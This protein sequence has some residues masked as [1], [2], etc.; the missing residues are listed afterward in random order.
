MDVTKYLELKIAPLAIFDALEERGDRVRFNVPEGD[1]RSPSGYRAV[2]YREFASEIRDAASF[3][4]T[5]LGAED[6]AAIFAP[7]RVEWASASLAI[8]AAGGVLV[9]VYP[10]N[11]A[12]QARYVLDHGDVKVVF[13]DTAPL[14]E[15]IFQI[16]DSLPGLARIALLGDELDWR[17]VRAAA[18]AKGL[19][20]RTH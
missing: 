5:L 14:L 1:P 18:E 4:G 11:T 9:P 17:A 2:T 12:E 16:A 8:Q 10:A 19:G 13:V 15:K 6:R 3:L 7:N 20:G